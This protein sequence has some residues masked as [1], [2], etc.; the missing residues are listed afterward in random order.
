MIENLQQT[1]GVKA[2][3]FTNVVHTEDHDVLLFVFSSEKGTK[4][5]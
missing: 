5:H 4:T 3:Q 1:R 2:S